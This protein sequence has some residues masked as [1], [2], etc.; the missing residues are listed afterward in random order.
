[1]KTLWKCRETGNIMYLLLRRNLTNKDSNKCNIVFI[2]SILHRNYYALIILSFVCDKIN[3]AISLK[4]WEIWGLIKIF[5]PKN[6]LLVRQY[7]LLKYRRNS[8]ANLSDCK[9][10][11]SKVENR[12]W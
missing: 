1:M 10:V 7:S 8:G 6:T 9:M 12:T 2:W 4:K 5:T 11:E 3:I